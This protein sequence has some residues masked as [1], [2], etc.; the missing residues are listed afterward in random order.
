MEILQNKCFCM[1]YISTFGYQSVFAVDSAVQI[2][3]IHLAHRT[4]RKIQFSQKRIKEG[5]AYNWL[6]RIGFL[7]HNP[8]VKRRKHWVTRLWL[9][10]HIAKVRRQWRTLVD[11]H[12]T[13]WRGDADLSLQIHTQLQSHRKALRSGYFLFYPITILPFSLPLFFVIVSSC[14]VLLAEARQKDTGGADRSGQ[15]AVCYWGFWSDGWACC[16]HKSKCLP[17]NS[18]ASTASE[19]H[20]S[21]QH[22]TMSFNAGIL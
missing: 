17:Q 16:F 13:H 18:H 21:C 14:S 11:S 4:T 19:P 9:T 6:S 2:W 3:I 15:V 7:I 1:K 8:I 12:P 22:A 20:R 5:D 10:N